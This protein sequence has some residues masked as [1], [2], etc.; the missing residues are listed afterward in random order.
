MTSQLEPAGYWCEAL[1]EGV[2]YGT[3][4]TVPYVLG[5]FQT[6]SPKLAL[7]WLQGEAARIADRLDP[8]PEHSAWAQP[9]MR[10]IPTPLPDSPTQLRCWASDPE[11]E[12]AARE[13]LR[14]GAPLS[15]VIPDIG[16]SYIFTAWPVNIPAPTTH[17]AAG[18]ATNP[19]PGHTSHRRTRRTAG[20]LLRPG[21]G[22]QT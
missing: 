21:R 3:H 7:R 20:W 18:Q 8:D 14:D 22:P 12:H 17:A 16:C 1:A 10:V 5:T 13:Q 15:L 11:G 9:W 6:I 2:V 19:R 4:E